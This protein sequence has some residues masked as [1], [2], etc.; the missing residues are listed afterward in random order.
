MLNWTLEILCLFLHAAVVY[1][2]YKMY[3]L[4]HPVRY[5]SNAWLLYSLGNLVILIRR[6]IGIFTIQ[7][8]IVPGM[9]LVWPATA[10]YLLQ[11][12]VSIL[13]LM[14]GMSLK[15][16]Y[17]KYFSDR[18]IVPSWKQEQ[19]QIVYD[20]I[21]D[22]IDKHLESKVRGNCSIC[23][24]HETCVLNKYAKYKVVKIPDNDIK[25]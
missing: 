1:Y 9:I 16:L 13:L 18:L 15:K 10:E 22:I 3:R 17:D 19:E 21:K 11:I 6:F 24:I 20:G 4:L 25:E 7:K 14:F 23:P 5:W 12:L 8:T 2:G